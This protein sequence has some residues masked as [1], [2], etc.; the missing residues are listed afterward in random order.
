[1]TSEVLTSQCSGNTNRRIR[2]RAFQFTIMNET[3]LNAIHDEL[4]N[5]KSC[6]YKIACREKAPETGKIHFHL[7]CHFTSQYCLKK[8][9]LDS[10]AHIEICKGSPQQNIAYIEKD[11]D[12]LF[13]EGN[14]PRQGQRTVGELRN[15]EDPDELNWNEYNTW[16]KIKNAPK[17]VSLKDW[18]KELKVYYIWGPSGSGKSNLARELAIKNGYDEIEEISYENGFWNGIVDGTGCAIFDDWR[19]SCMKPSE[20]V[21]FIDYNIH[22]INIKGGS[23]QNRYSL[24]I[25][26][27]VRDPNEIYKGMYSDNEE[28]EKQ[29]LR[30]MEIIN[31]SPKNT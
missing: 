20:F 6:D 12:I 23:K 1:M 7:Y 13:E 17:K 19:P 11:G 30:R 26:T 14:R 21:K 25:I 18:H 5:L 31:L 22:T 4:N 8:A 10:G 15:I 27:S 16:N 29:W 28:P 2:A 24:I 9:F 3:T